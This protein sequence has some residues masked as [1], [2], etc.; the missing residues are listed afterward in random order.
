MK[1]LTEKQE[2][3]AYLGDSPHQPPISSQIHAQEAPT[4]ANTESMDVARPPTPPSS[5]LNRVLAALILGFIAGL[6]VYGVETHRHAMGR[7][8]FLASQSQLWDHRYTETHAAIIFGIILAIGAGVGLYEFLAFA[9]DK[10]LN[11]TRRGGA[12]R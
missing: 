10:A 6:G 7:D 3:E 9:I 4:A 5:G 1:T 8:A 2:L 11:R 12:N